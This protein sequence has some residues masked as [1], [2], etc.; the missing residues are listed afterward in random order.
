MKAEERFPETYFGYAASARLAA[1]GREPVNPAGVLEKIPPVPANHSIS[2][3]IPPAAAARWARAEALRTIAFDAFA[4]LELRAAYFGTASPRIIFEAS[5][6]ALD[7]GHY[8]VAMSLGRLAFPNLEAH[9]IDEVPAAVWHTVFP[10]PYESYVRRYAEENGV[11]RMLV[12]GLIKQES[13]FQNDAISRAG[14]IGLMQVLPKT[15]RKMAKRLKLRYSREK[16][17]DPEYNIQVG[18]LYLS[19]L[20]KQFGSPEAALAAFNAGEDRIGAWQAERAYEEVAELVES[21]PFTET[22]EYIQ[23]VRRNTEVYRMLYGETK[24]AEAEK[25]QP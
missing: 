11:D 8:S 25:Q 10:L 3:P 17:F 1:I 16:L 18:T 24:K 23:I 4:E 14:A 2:E 20:L 19:D 7:Q 13:I 12:A 21:V 9:K 22:R 15:G 6:A 5:Q